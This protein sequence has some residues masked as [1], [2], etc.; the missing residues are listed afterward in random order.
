MADVAVLGTGRMG[1]AMVRR[2]A[3]GGHHVRV[4]NRT[5]ETA[6]RLVA[7]VSTPAVQLAETAPSAVRGAPVVITMLADG[8]ATCAVLLDGEMLDALAADTIVVDHGTTGVANAH[9]LAEGLEAVGVRFVDAP[10][11]GSVPAVLSGSLLV[12]AAGDPDAIEAV[13]PTLA[14]YARDVVRVGD[15]GSGQAMKLAVNLVVHDLNAALSEA[16]Q[17]A[18]K[19]GISREDAYAVLLQSVVAAPFVT[20]KRAAFLDASTPVAMSLALVEKDLALIV[21]HAAAVG[22]GT[23]VTAAAL[24]EVGEAVRRGM[25]GR[26]MAD[27]SRVDAPGGPVQP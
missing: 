22:A 18:E 16:L 25:G 3:E 11:S 8:G 13:R 14:A 27:L 17:M 1:A 24:A 6:E 21:E 12:M 15:V 4:W 7:E 5:A 10:V 23:R 19:S 20:Y 9:A 26:D 2:L